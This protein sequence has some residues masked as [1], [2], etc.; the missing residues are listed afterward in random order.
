MYNNTNNFKESILKYEETIFNEYFYKRSKLIENI[1]SLQLNN[2][3]NEQLLNITS[4][5]K[6]IIDPIRTSIINIDDYF[7]N[8]DVSFKNNESIKTINNLENFIKNYVFLYFFLGSGS[9]SGSSSGS[10]SE[11]STSSSSYSTSSSSYSEDS[12]E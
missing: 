4:D 7:I 12:S 10:D 6:L 1:K 8:L 5:L 9:G 2:L 11:H 3:D